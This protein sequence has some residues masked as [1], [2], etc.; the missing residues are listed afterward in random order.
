VRAPAQFLGNFPDESIIHAS[1][2]ASLSHGFSRQV[3][4][5][6]RT[7]EYQWVF[8][9]ILPAKDSSSVEQWHIEGHRG[10][11]V[12][13]GVGGP[14]TGKGG[15]LIIDDPVKNAEEARSEVVRSNTI[16]WYRRDA[17]TRLPPGG[18]IMLIQ[19]RWHMGD[20]TGFLMEE[21]R[22]GTG[23]PWHVMILP[24]QAK[25][26][27]FLWPERF[28]KEEYETMKMVSGRYG[29]PALYQQNPIP[30]GGNLI[31]GAWFKV[32]HM[33]DV[34]SLRKRSVA[35]DI[36]VKEKESADF[37][38]VLPGG[39]GVED[40]QIYVM[41]PYWNQCEWPEGRA[42]I[43][44]RTL[45][46]RA[47]IIGV[48]SVGAQYM[49]VSQLRKDLRGRAIAVLEL[50]VDKDKGAR[51][52]EWTPLAE[53]GQITLVEDGTGWTTRA[54]MQMEEFPYGAHDD[55]VDAMGHLIHCLRVKG[56]AK[57]LK[58]GDTYETYSP[59]GP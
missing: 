19:T 14:I 46:F 17:Y 45:G 7:P 55:L 50:Q 3:R 30:E 18:W 23:E 38:V 15:N 39:I 56:E 13:A 33:K 42:Q 59:G 37:T 10:G 57:Q 5:V 36:A 44:N 49:A 4:N 52:A 6:L 20:L 9:G 11:M 48:E 34:P 31:K 2:G 12:S 8:P 51:V 28:S 58:R 54:L 16:E 41:P 1:Y 24:A 53:S 47:T 22:Q 43:I 29:W 35:V 40:G 27:S 32:I 21:A 25:D 26:G